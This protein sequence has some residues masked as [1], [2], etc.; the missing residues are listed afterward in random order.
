[1]PTGIFSFDNAS[2]SAPVSRAN[3]CFKLHAYVRPMTGFSGP[4]VIAA[5][6]VHVMISDVRR[7]WYLR[8]T[9]ALSGFTSTNLLLL[10]QTLGRL[11]SPQVVLHYI[12]EYRGK[13]CMINV[14]EMWVE[15]RYEDCQS[16]RVVTMCTVHTLTFRKQYC[17]FRWLHNDTTGCRVRM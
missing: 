13:P 16:I 12:V 11:V 8:K 4:K 7:W 5:S 15:P 3:L 9:N 1:M 6:M 14:L 10:T 2:S 17:W